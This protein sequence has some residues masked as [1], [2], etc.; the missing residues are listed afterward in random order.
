MNVK[1]IF[2]DINTAIPVGMLANEIISNSLKHGFPGGRKG[3]IYIDL[4]STKDNYILK[5]G[6]NGI[7]FTEKFDISHSKSFGMELITTLAN[8]LNA[9]LKCDKNNG[10]HYTIKIPK[11]QANP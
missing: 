4:Q 1:R 6:D 7:G 9:S 10:V 2:F 8:Q 11:N 3:E 5:I